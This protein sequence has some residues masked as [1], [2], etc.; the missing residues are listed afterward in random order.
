MI[1]EKLLQ[2]QEHIESVL[3]TRCAPD[4]TLIKEKFLNI[5]VLLSGWLAGWV[6]GAGG[7][8]DRLTK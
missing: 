3:R 1:D 8:T 7:P 6:V 5:E 4:K 2:N